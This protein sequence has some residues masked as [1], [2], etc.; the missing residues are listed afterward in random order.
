MN[1]HF[2]VGVVMALGLSAASAVTVSDVHLSAFADG[3]QMC[4]TYQID[5][6]A[7]VTLEILTNGVPVGGS[8]LRLVSGDV[9]KYVDKVGETCSILWRPTVEWPTGQRIAPT[10]KARVRA[11]PVDSPPTYMALNLLDRD[12][13]RYYA[14]EE[15][16]PYP[17]TDSTYKTD[18]LLMRK[19]PAAGV[20]W[21]M[22][23]QSG[24]PV[25]WRPSATAE[26]PH[27][28]RLT[29]DYYIGVYEMTVAQH[30]RILGDTIVDMRPRA[31]SYNSLRGSKDEV[32]WPNTEPLHKVAPTS[33]LAEYR[34]KLGL[35]LDL[36]TEAQW[37][38]ACRAGE[39]ASLYDGTASSQPDNA[40]RLGWFSGSLAAAGLSGAQPPGQLV[41]NNWNL[42][43]LYG[44]ISEWCLDWYDDAD[45]TPLGAEDPKG[46]TSG[47]SRVM[48]GGDLS[49]NGIG[50]SALRIGGYAPGDGYSN[51][52]YRLVA[53]AVAP[54]KTK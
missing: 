44:N 43:D 40:N 19:I 1:R 53:P 18:W 27:A 6:P 48:R 14:S 22:G 36:P 28:V 7:I 16:L 50:R 26:T 31:A 11:W 49:A 51:L 20:T 10:V 21:T 42:Y 32:D 3:R 29:K 35:E 4:V 30:Y 54:L 33:T 38:Y 47:T 2:A 39:G 17:I 9:N 34:E 12:I 24:T 46:V 23:E 52:G 45:L 41:P 8:A 5:T 13:V 37:E 15:E 25:V